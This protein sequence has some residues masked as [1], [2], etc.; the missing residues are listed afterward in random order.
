MKTDLTANVSYDA[1][2]LTNAD[3]VYGIFYAK[4]DIATGL[5]LA[6]YFELDKNDEWSFEPAVTINAGSD[7]FYKT[8]L[9]DIK[10]HPEELV[11]VL[12]FYEFFSLVLVYYYC[13]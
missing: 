13:I 1:D 2:S 5:S 7:S 10:Y 6:R 8:Y 11:S 12:L 3:E 9:A 4:A